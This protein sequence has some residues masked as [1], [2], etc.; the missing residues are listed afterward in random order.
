METL[1]G[2]ENNKQFVGKEKDKETG[3]YYFGARYMNDKIGRF[4]S[5]DPGKFNGTVLLNDCD[6]R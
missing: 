2:A 6:D 1:A 5:T 4:I 3:L